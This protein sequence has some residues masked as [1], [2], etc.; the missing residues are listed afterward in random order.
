VGKL[1]SV[2]AGTV[3][4][5]I[6]LSGCLPLEWMQYQDYEVARQILQWDAP[7]RPNLRLHT[8]FFVGDEADEGNVAP[9]EQLPERDFTTDR[10]GFRDTRPIV[11]GEP[12][13][14]VVF[15]G[16][17]FTF[18]AGLSDTQTL[19][20]VLERELRVNAYNAGRFH[21]DPETPE[22]FDRLMSR[23]GARPRTVVYVHLEPNGHVGVE[24]PRPLKRLLRFAK[25]LPMNWIR[26]SPAIRYAA[27]AKKAMENNLLLH[28]R[29]GD[30]LRSFPLPDG[31][32]FLVLDRE[33]EHDTAEYD[34]G[35][36]ADRA[37]YIAWWGQRMAE[38]GARMVVLLVPDKMSVYGRE[39]GVKLPE[40]AYLD[41]MERQLEHRGLRVVNGLRLLRATAR[42][43][44]ASGRLAFLR[45][46]QHWSVSGVDRLG[47]ATATAIRSDN[48]AVRVSEAR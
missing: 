22:D 45:E 9:T 34:D 31:R 35:L 10:L 39:L 41:R 33:L 15:R 26:S 21:D 1:A 5:L 13:K 37:D 6:V 4:A 16:F 8:R 42:E 48:G 28:N 44:L 7:F 47:K 20:A 40:D 43:D 32:R 19:P 2:L 17:S 18:G 46:D 29:Y 12:V 36:V 38:R 25:E 14:L 30:H 24:R 23:I 3:A 11:P 27:L